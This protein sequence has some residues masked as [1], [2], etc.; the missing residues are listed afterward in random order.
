M[1]MWKVNRRVSKGGFLSVGTRREDECRTP[2][3]IRKASERCSETLIGVLDELT[4]TNAIRLG[5]GVTYQFIRPFINNRAALP[6]VSR[7]PS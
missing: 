5:R 6:P 7:G 1:Y 2:D 3:F 4:R